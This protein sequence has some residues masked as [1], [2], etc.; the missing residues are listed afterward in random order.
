MWSNFIDYYEDG[1]AFFPEATKCYNEIDSAFLSFIKNYNIFEVKIPSL[2]SEDILE[3]CGY[4]ETF[5]QHLTQLAAYG[6]QRT[7][8]K[9]CFLTPAACIHIYPMLKK[10]FHMNSCYTTLE[11]VYRYENGN[12]TNEERL[13]EFTV[14]EIVFVG[15]EKFVKEAL[16]DIECKAL[17]Y[18]M[19]FNPDAKIVQAHDS[20]V[21]SKE[22]LI[23][24]KL[25]T[26]NHLKDEL[27]VHY[28]G[29]E[30]AI[31][32]FNFHGNHFSKTFGFD[33]NNKV[34]TGCVGF[35]MERWMLYL[36][37]NS[38]TGENTER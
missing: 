34:V 35:G 22:N 20:F 31:A 24:E 13:W 26:A 32:S 4:F 25:Q 30:I 38:G 36:D 29:R 6:E 17:E 7:T 15:Q 14:R 11:R 28:K 8:K 33:Q 18:A 12:F 23:R 10:G 3:K 19:G 16:K 21:P 27:I 37:E 5:P 2:I 9:K 1:M